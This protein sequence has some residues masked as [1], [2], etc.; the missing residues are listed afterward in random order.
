MHL[1]SLSVSN[2]IFSHNTA[3]TGQ[4]PSYIVVVK[5]H[6]CCFLNTNAN[7][8]V[9]TG[10]VEFSMNRLR[11]SQ[12]FLR[13]D[14]YIFLNEN[15]KLLLTSNLMDR[16]QGEAVI[17]VTHYQYSTSSRYQGFFPCFIQYVSFKNSLD[18]E[19]KYGLS[20]L[21][22]S[23]VIKNNINF[24]RAI[25]LNNLKDCYWLPQSS[26]KNAHPGMVAKRFVTFDENE[27]PTGDFYNDCLCYNSSYTADCFTDEIGPVYPG[28][29]MTVGFK[30]TNFEHDDHSQHYGQVKLFG[31]G[32]V[33]C[34]LQLLNL[35]KVTA[36]QCLFKNITIIM[37][38]NTSDK[39]ECS[40]QHTYFRY[41]YRGN[42]RT[43][44]VRNSIYYIL[45]LPCPPGFSLNNGKC[46][47]H[48]K[49][50]QIFRFTECFIEN[51]TVL[52]TGNTWMMY[53]NMTRDVLYVEYCPFHYCWPYSLYIQ[54][55]DADKQCNH[56]RRGILC[57]QC[58]EGYSA[59]FG[60]VR[61]KRCSNAWLASAVIFMIV[62]ILLV[63]GLFVSKV[64]FRNSFAFLFYVN[65]LYTISQNV[66]SPDF[67]FS[68]SFAF[69]LLS[70]VNFDLGFEV[71][72][73]NGMTEYAK[74]WLQFIFPI[75]M[76]CIVSLLM[77]LSK[78]VQCMQRLSTHNGKSTLLLIIFISYNKAVIAL[79]KE[80]FYYKRL[81]FLENARTQL[82]WSVYPSV[83]LFNSLHLP[84]F[85]FCLTL[86][87]LVI[88]M[89]LFT[90]FPSVFGKL[91]N[92]FNFFQDI[93]KEKHKYWLGLQL[94]L[95][96]T[97]ALFMVLNP[98]LSL[99][100]IIMTTIV[101]IS[102][103][104][105]V[106]PFKDARNTV[107]EWIFTVNLIFISLLALYYGEEKTTIYNTLINTLVT[108]S[109]ATF[110]IHQIN[111]ALA[112]KVSQ[113]ANA[114]ICNIFTM[115]AKHFS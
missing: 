78:Y 107:L 32:T 27:N 37:A 96:L 42:F 52:R 111:I 14:H 85:I 97:T 68:T 45:I 72:F 49:L 34:H 62:G 63:L 44:I 46:V 90:L 66:F 108:L 13:I 115:A 51:Q 39:Y 81:I 10:H 80:F 82:V 54:L 24:L 36:E 1:K 17:E 5:I 65:I 57:G 74:L 102:C 21:N 110:I 106:C 3:C 22:Y 71:C 76:I 26:F 95:Q 98:Q 15:T 99:T 113:F 94:F 104:G 29:T 9:F 2:T 77:Y 100:L 83:S 112:D 4:M 58:L 60:S 48:I 53:S 70:L 18:D 73:Y 11:Q 86:T 8:I 30:L 6:T 28:Q 23:V 101:F 19:F 92:Y 88:I 114:V 89:I 79:C 64:H 103:L 43:K 50:L 38:E 47:C 67:H 105:F 84:Y 35:S 20:T 7:T 16:I 59:V 87:V 31:W 41:P 55:T 69:V 75:Y 12:Y 109:F 40:F 61:C 56:N 93:V 33:P 91:Y 25:L